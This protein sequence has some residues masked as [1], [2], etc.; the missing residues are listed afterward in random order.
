VHKIRWSLT[1]D[2]SNLEEAIWASEKGFY[3]KDD[4]YNGINL[5][6]VY[7]VRASISEGLDV[8]TDFV[9]AQRTRRRVIQLCQGLLDQTRTT[10]SGKWFDRDAK[11]SLLAILAEAWTGVGN[12]AESQNCLKQARA[13]NPPPPAWFE[14]SAQEQLGRLQALLAD[15]RLKIGLNPTEPAASRSK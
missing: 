13:L 14:P 11:Y 3:L 7:N 9:L 5:A 2:R 4:Y 6:Y 8:V 10:T 12:E 1:G 15:L